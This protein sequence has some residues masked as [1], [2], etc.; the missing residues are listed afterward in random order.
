MSVS[1]KTTTEITVRVTADLAAMVKGQVASGRYADSSAVVGDALRQMDAR[2]R[3][4]NHLRALVQEWLD[5]GDAV[6]LTDELWEEIWQEAEARLARGEQP[7][8][9]VCP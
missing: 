1:E 8:P 3:Q 2:E 7:S 4:L 5:S 6:E 9:V